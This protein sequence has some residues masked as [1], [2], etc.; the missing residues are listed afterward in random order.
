MTPHFRWPEFACRCGCAAP[1]S[2]IV[3]YQRMAEVLEV[4]RAEVKA[5]VS[6]ISG[7]RCAKRNAAVGGASSSQH[8]VGAAVDIQVEGHTGQSLAAL[9]EGLIALGKMPD[10]GL[11]T[12]SSKRLTC[13]YDL[14]RTK[15]RW[16]H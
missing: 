5:P 16:H 15:A 6:I 14:R 8:L 9:I 12:Y 1:Q 11:G 4:L 13:H 2:V 7:Y 3:S 10:G